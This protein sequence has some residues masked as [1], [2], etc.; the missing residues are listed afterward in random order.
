MSRNCT[1]NEWIS[2]NNQ[3]NLKQNKELKQMVALNQ[4]KISK[5]AD[6]QSIIQ[7]INH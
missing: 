2:F 4:Y 1:L 5:P 7:A 3:V 6:I